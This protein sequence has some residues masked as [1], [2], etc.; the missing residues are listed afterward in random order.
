MPCESLTWLAA[1]KSSY[2]CMAQC[3]AKGVQVILAMG[4]A[5]GNYGFDSAADAISYVASYT[6]PVT[7]VHACII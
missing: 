1:V 7:M 2:A 3:Q 6:A 5:I 4:G